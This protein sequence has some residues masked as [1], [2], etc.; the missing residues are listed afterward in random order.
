MKST[1]GDRVIVIVGI[2]GCFQP[3]TEPLKIPIE[4]MFRMLRRLGGERDL[5]RN[6][7]ATLD[8]ASKA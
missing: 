5:V 4:E 7:P 3:A 8:A 1:V 6:L 2:Q